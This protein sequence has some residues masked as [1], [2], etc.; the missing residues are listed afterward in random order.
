MAASREGGRPGPGARDAAPGGITSRRGSAP[1][2]LPAACRDAGRAPRG[3]PR[4]CG[5]GGGAG[6]ASCGLPTC[7]PSSRSV[8]GPCPARRTAPEGI[9]PRP[10]AGRAGAA[11]VE[12]VGR[13][14]I[15][16]RAGTPPAGS[17][18]PT[19]QPRPMRV[20]SADPAR[21][22]SPSIATHARDRVARDRVAHKGDR[23]S[24]RLVAAPRPGPGPPRRRVPRR[25]PRPGHPWI[26]RNAAETTRKARAQACAPVPPRRTRAR[27]AAGA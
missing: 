13:V 26:G 27:R 24:D 7:R 3:G 1:D 21:G 4:P 6:P 25:P 8:A 12:G 22:G 5:A 2:A 15:G 14:V 16:P 10:G 11:R 9:R 18:V 23:P 17:A 20:V 19:I